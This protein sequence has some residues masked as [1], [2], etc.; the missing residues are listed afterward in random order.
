MNWLITCTCIL[1]KK[2]KKK[3]VEKNR[4]K[5]SFR[6]NGGKTYIYIYILGSISAPYGIREGA[7]KVGKEE[8]VTLTPD[9]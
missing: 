7:K 6:Y 5:S 4:S 8:A 2:K 3:L 1:K 9:Q